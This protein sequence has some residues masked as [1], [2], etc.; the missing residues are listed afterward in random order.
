MNL[1]DAVQRA[2]EAQS[3]GL[4]ARNL[5]CYR[6]DQ[7]LFESLDLRV[8]PGELLRIEGANGAGK[9]S[10]LRILSGLS[11]PDAGE[12]CWAGTPIEKAQSGFARALGYLGHLIGLKLDLT[13]EENLRVMAALRGQSPEPL[14]LKA[15]LERL[16]LWSRRDLR[17]R[18]LSQGQ[19]QRTALAA[20]VL[21]GGPLW[22]L[23]EPFTALDRAGVVLTESLIDTH[24]ESGGLVVLSSHQPLSTR[25][26][27][28]RLGL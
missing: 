6:G 3:L 1:Q 10:L 19:R 16:D 28:R 11:R 22:I 2:N 25:A 27:A 14:A 5:A 9:T 24:L 4:E 12:V 8:G 26:V 20:L 7:C 17:A 13:L 23:D 21:F 18:V 15:L